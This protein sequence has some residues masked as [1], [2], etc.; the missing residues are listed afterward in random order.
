MKPSWIICL[1]LV[2]CQ[3][4]PPAIPVHPPVPAA[5]PA[6]N[7]REAELEARLQQQRYV[8]D[9]LLSQQE[10]MREETREIPARR[11]VQRVMPQETAA[12]IV[13]PVGSAPIKSIQPDGNGVIDLA[14]FA[15]KAIDAAASNPFVVPAAGPAPG[16][17]ITLHVQGVLS[18]ANPSAIVNDRPVQTGEAVESLRL[19]RVEPDAGFFSAG[20]HLLR[21]PL[22]RP[23]R[24]R[25]P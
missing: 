7:R 22:G 23:I 24:V 14:I 21:I 18:G 20:E 16:R 15:A 17:E 3:S 4:A 19:V 13:A 11:T 10:A 6:P 5:V 2:G 8:I 12:V 25:L 1:L 9:A